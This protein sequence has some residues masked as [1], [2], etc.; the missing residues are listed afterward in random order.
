MALLNY[1]AAAILMPYKLFHDEC[2]KQKYDLE[3]IQKTYA[4]SFEQVAFTFFEGLKDLQLNIEKRIKA[5][6][7][8][9]GA[10][11]TLFWIGM[12][13]NSLQS[14][15]QNHNLPCQIIQTSTFSEPVL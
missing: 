10:G 9:T 1:C 2:K 11:P 12:D 14:N 4:N 6:V 5:P 15:F 7:H 13:I 8:L 3:L